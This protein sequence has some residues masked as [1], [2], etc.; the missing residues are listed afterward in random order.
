MTERVLSQGIFDPVLFTKN[1]L[2]AMW[3]AF[4]NLISLSKS[5]F[6]VP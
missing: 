5:D 4:E 3:E 6:A 1:T 2:S